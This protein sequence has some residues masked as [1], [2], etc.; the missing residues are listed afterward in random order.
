MIILKK[1]ILYFLLLFVLVILIY[2]HNDNNNN[3][4]YNVQA[5]DINLKT[6]FA[7]I[8]EETRPAVVKVK[9]TANQETDNFEFYEESTEDNKERTVTGTG[10]IIKDSG[11][12]LTNKHLV[13]QAEEININLDGKIFSAE[14][15]GSDFNLDLAILKIDTDKNL[16]TVEL[17]SSDNLRPGDWVI[18]IG[19]PYGYQRIT[20]F[21][22]ISA[23]GR[24]V[25]LKENGQSRN[26][27]NLIQTDAAINPGN[28]G[29]PLLNIQGEVIGI[30]TAID[31]QKQNVSYAVP[32]SDFK[33]VIT[34]IKEHGKILRP[35]TGLQV[36]EISKEVAEFMGLD[37]SERVLI[38][39]VDKESPA[40]EAGIQ[41]GDIIIEFNEEEIKNST[42]FRQ[43]VANIEI[44]QEISLIIFRD[45][46]KK[47]FKLKITEM[48]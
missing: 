13:S 40:K 11:Y 18:A 9:S 6:V 45:D 44:G 46:E 47:E 48:P 29:G 35:W 31:T 41:A 12:I 33:D 15:I 36:Q 22:I 25:S 19:N 42:D 23:L 21:G 17:S 37:S 39:S 4:K 7:D 27:N 16:P 24:S 20:T 28:S 8:S 26:Y 43:K 32:S 38:S 14:K 2:N 3:F 1:I 10:F 34:E 30:N 5:E